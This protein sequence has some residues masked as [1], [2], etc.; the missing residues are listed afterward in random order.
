MKKRLAIEKKEIKDFDWF[1]LIAVNKGANRRTYNKDEGYA[2]SLTYLFYNKVKFSKPTVVTSHLPIAAD[3]SVPKGRL[4]S[5]TGSHTNIS[6][7]KMI[8][9]KKGQSA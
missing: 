9:R 6:P 4:R 5:D 7:S 8:L 3:L 2:L 1:S